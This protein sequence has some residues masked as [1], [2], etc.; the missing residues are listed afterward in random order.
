MCFWDLSIIDVIF[1]PQKN[2]RYLISFLFFLEKC[3]KRFNKHSTFK[4]K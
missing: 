2:L 3:V 4:E 1:S